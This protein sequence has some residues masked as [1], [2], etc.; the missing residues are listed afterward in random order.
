MRESASDQKRMEVQLFLPAPQLRLIPWMSSRFCE[1][2][3][4]VGIDREMYEYAVERPSYYVAINKLSLKR[5]K[6]PLV[7]ARE[8]V[9]D[10]VVSKFG[11]GFLQFNETS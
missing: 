11:I 6:H 8:N 7:D 9:K 3:V 10:Q 2:Y 4:C 5:Y 1:L